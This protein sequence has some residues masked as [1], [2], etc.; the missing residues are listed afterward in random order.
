[1]RWRESG[2]TSL[3]QLRAMYKSRLWSTYWKRT[4]S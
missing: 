4:V 1:M 2:T 3:C